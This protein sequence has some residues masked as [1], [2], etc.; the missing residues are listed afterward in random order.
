MG[1]AGM[2]KVAVLT[3]TRGDYS[4]YISVLDAIDEYPGLDYELIVTGMHLSHK[5]GY[6]V[7]E[8]KKD[9]RKI[10]A[11]VP[12]LKYEDTLAGMTKN[13]GVAVI[14]IAEALEK[15]EPDVV[16]VLG[17][18][19]EQLAAAMAGAHMN[20]PVAHLHGGEVSGTI[21]ESIR[22]AVTKFAHIHLAATKKSRERIIRLGEKEENVYLVG[23]PGIDAVKKKGRMSRKE[24]ADYFSFDPDKIII[25]AVQHPVTTEF[26]EAKKNMKVLADSLIE[27]DKQTV[28]V[29]SNSDAGY[30]NMMEMLELGIRDAGKE[31]RM[32]VY[33]SLAHEVYL[34]LMKQAD[35][36]IGN[37]SSGVIEAPSC[38]TPYV[39]V[40]TRQAGREKAESVLDAGYDKDEIL[41]AVDKALYDKEFKEIVKTSEK[42]YDPFNDTYA[43]RRT[44]EALAAF[45][46]TP[47]LLQKR[48]TY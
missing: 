46:I 33:R 32:K 10:G 9:G 35:V 44:A 37:S 19:G 26:E 11:E 31:K 1:Y 42:P 48:I 6:T 14:G 43:G 41:K 45:R 23:A 3:G 38:Q 2:R 16:L 8:I 29:Y 17:D 36:M 22:H 40:G 47:E 7:D 20:L 21:D 5:F 12:M 28:F 30:T 18:R 4:V 39:L 34:S 15:T 25:L 27:L 13:T 24:V